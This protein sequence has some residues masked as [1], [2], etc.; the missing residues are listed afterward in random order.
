MEQDVRQTESKSTAQRVVQTA[1]RTFAFLCLPVASLTCLLNPFTGSH[2][3]E[4]I[5]WLLLVIGWAGLLLLRRWGAVLVCSAGWFLIGH[6]LWDTFEALSA[7]PI[8]PSEAAFC[9]NIL[10]VMSLLTALLHFAGRYLK[11]GL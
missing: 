5:P 11:N 10:L 8:D 7:R 3:L 6:G 1:V 2:D 9:A 4:A